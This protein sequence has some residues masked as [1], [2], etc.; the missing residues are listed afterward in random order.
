MN[1]YDNASIAAAIDHTLLKP[2]ARRVD[3]DRICE[4]ALEHRFAAVCVNSLWVP[5]VSRQ[6]AG[7]SVKTCSVVGFPLGASL[8][9]ATAAEARMAIDAGAQEID[10]VLSVGEALAGD[11]DAVHRG[12]AEVLASCSEVPLKVI[13]E[14]CLLTESHKRLACEI[15]RDLGVAFVKTS[16]GFST[17]GATVEDVALMR[18]VVGLDIG[19]KASGGIRDRDTAI[20]MLN[21]GANRLGCSAGVAIVTGGVGTEA[22]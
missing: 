10:M 3:I 11:W 6:L 2:E 18:S 22:Y 21:A 9:A 15:C 14:T 20:A 5:R 13:L 1:S 4:E 19:V 17:G 8:P 7:S 16:T 12:I